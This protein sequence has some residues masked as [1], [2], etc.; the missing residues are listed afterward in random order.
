MKICSSPSSPG[1]MIG[2][3]D[4]TMPF[5]HVPQGAFTVAQVCR[6]IPELT[7]GGEIR[8]CADRVQRLRGF[9]LAHDHR[10]RRQHDANALHGAGG[11]A[12]QS[13]TTGT[14]GGADVPGPSPRVGIDPRPG[15]VGSFAAIEG[16]PGRREVR[17]T[18]AP[19]PPR[20]VASCCVACR[21]LPQSAHPRAQSIDGFG[22]RGGQTPYPLPGKQ[23]NTLEG[24]D[25]PLAPSVPELR[26]R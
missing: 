14:V 1:S 10:G 4:P 13:M 22:D 11:D 23:T 17:P 25:D 19:G 7:A 12:G 24:L 26:G 2:R 3:G 8:R 18:D 9:L 20:A 15:G 16:Q 5:A 6:T 21:A